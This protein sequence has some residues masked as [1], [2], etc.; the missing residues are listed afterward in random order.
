MCARAT[1]SRS[2]FLH[3][4][5]SYRVGSVKSSIIEFHIQSSIMFGCCWVT[6][7]GMR[8]PSKL[9]ESKFIVLRNGRVLATEGC[10]S[11]YE[12][13]FLCWPGPSG[14]FLAEGVG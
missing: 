14:S 5:K 6:E 10:S 9:I 13:R 4:T 8:M 11:P 7:P 12:G 2:L 3:E 1:Q